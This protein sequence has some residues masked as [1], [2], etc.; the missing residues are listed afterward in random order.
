[1][2]KRRKINILF[3]I[4]SVIIFILSSLSHFL[5]KWSNYNDF[6]GIFAPTN[7]SVFQHLKMFFYPTIIYYF[8]TYFLFVKKYDISANKWYLCPL[9]TVVFTSVVVV[10]SYYVFRYALNV[11]SMF[12]DISSLFIGLFTSSLICKHI[13]N[14]KKIVK[15]PSYVTIVLIL[16]LTISVAYYDSNPKNVDLFYDNE[17]KTYFEAKD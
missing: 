10:C 15:F 3:Y 4:S 13:Y 2:E 16:I 11:E 1:M 14:R 12:I 17:N 6:I 5:Y 8:V 7:E 9:I